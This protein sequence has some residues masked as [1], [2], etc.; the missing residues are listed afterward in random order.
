MDTLEMICLANAD[1]FLQLIP[2]TDDIRDI[3]KLCR[4]STSFRDFFFATLPGRHAWLRT[5][6]LL[7]GY[8]GYKVIDVRV[9]DFQYQLKL[10]VCPWL[11]QKDPLFFQIPKC[12]WANN[13]DIRVISNSRLLFRAQNTDTEPGEDQS[14]CVISF[15]S[16]RCSSEHSFNKTLTH[17]PIDFPEVFAPDVDDGLVELILNRKLIPELSGSSSHLFRHIHKNA[18]AILESTG[19]GMAG[20]IYLMSSRNPLE[21]QFLRHM[22]CACMDNF[23]DNDLCSA[24]QRMWLMT[25]E[26][27]FFFGPRVGGK[28]LLCDQTNNKIGRMTP[29][30][31]MAFKGDAAGAIDFMK[32]TIE[33]DI[34]T[35]S[36]MNG[37]PLIYF[38]ICRDK[39]E[40]LRLLIETRAKVNFLDDRTVS[41]LMLAASL[42]NAECVRVL[43]ENGANARMR[44]IHN[45][46]ALLFIG[47]CSNRGERLACF[48]SSP[49]SNLWGFRDCW[50]NHRDPKLPHR[51]WRRPQRHR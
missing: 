9:T 1:L 23:V 35:P 15:S 8:D 45:K 27:I 24:P 38:P 29:A 5:A 46:T 17:L 36:L 47:E 44:G 26:S 30:L 16:I 51:C 37:R 7:T 21:P 34:N 41:P 22:V 13:K 18:F 19:I 49:F 28:R 25:S 11:E 50:R 2:D 20:S 39:P 33:L 43:C 4:V 3:A 12:D 31:W 32:T 10:L 48:P 6:S 40:A 42:V 14:S